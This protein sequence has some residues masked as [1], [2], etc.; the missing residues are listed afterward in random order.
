MM[1]SSRSTESFVAGGR[2]LEDAFFLEQDRLLVERRAQL[3]RMEKTKEALAEISG[4]QDQAVL[5]QLVRLDISPETLAALAVVPLVEVVWADGQVD[6]KERAAVF[7]HAEK[8]GIRSG[9][10]E[11]DLLDRWLRHRPGA[12]LLE[13]WRHHVRALCSRLAPSARDS[14]K[15][16]LLRDVRGAAQ[17]SGGFLGLRAI[18]SQEQAVLDKLES[19]FRE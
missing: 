2:S 6:D 8:Q 10:I 5:D 1:E 19:S 15:G 16:E 11:R 14:L 9:T 7:A 3:H 18:S 13:A 4:I 12:D 17:A